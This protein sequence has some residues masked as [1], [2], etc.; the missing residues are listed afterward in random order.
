MPDTAWE[1]TYSVE[2][3]ASLAF[4]WNY[5]TNVANWDE[6]PAKFDLDG[7]FASGTHGTTHMPGQ[8]PLR[9]LL[10]TVSPPNSAVID[11]ELERAVLSFEWRFDRLREGRTRLTQR[12]VLEG[13]SAATFR[14]QVQ[15]MFQSSL[16]DGMKKLARAIADAETRSK[17]AG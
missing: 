13:E 15:S 9:W 12:V 17:N 7:P 16:P 1:L 2:T 11:F 14:P 5:W 6:P 3:D 8:E 4:A 10:R